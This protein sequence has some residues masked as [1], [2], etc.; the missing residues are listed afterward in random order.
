MVRTVTH[1]KVDGK[2]KATVIRDAGKTSASIRTVI[3]S[4]PVIQILKTATCKEGYILGGVKP[5]CY[6]TYKRLYQAAFEY[7]GIKGKYTPYD[8]RTTFGTE[9]CEAGLSSK[10]V[11]D[12]MGHADS[13]MVDTVYANPRHEGIMK[14]R[15]VLERLNQAYII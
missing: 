11:G 9:L 10:Q 7:L 12:M 1:A 6:S 4:T 8:F 3:L 5:L 2:E 14:Q 13:R 15:D